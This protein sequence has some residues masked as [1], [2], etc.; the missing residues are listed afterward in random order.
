[1][2]INQLNKLDT[3][4]YLKF[5]LEEEVEH[6]YIDA[7]KLL[8]TARFDFYGILIYIDHKV[9]GLKDLSFAKSVYFERTQA[10]TGFRFKENGNSKKSSFDVFLVALD[11]LIDA[12]LHDEFEEDRTYIPVDKNLVPLDGAHRVA[13]A[14]YFGR[15]LHILRFLKREY[16]FSGFQYLKKQLLP[17][18][19]ADTMA[20]E[21]TKW[22]DDLFVFF[23]WPQAHLNQ[24]KLETAMERIRNS[25]DELYETN[26]Y[27]SSHGLWNLMLQIY[28]HMDWI[29]NVDNGYSNLITKVDEVWA[30]NGLVHLMIVRANSCDFVMKI[31]TELRDFFE[32]GLSSIHSTDNIEETRLALSALLNPKSR[33]FLEH[34]YPTTYKEALR[35]CN[36]FRLSIKN[37]GLK[38]DDFVIDSSM[39]LAIYGAREANDLDYYCLPGTDISILQTI[40][41]V[42]EHD[43]TQQSFYQLPVKDYILNTNNY[44]CFNGLK[45]I[46]LQQL[47]LFKR[48][49]YAAIRDEKDAIDIKL[50]SNLLS[51][52][53]RWIQWII[54]QRYTLLRKYRIFYNGMYALIFWRRKEI[55]QKVGLYKPLKT[56]KTFLSLM[57][58]SKGKV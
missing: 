11:K 2:T 40:Q 38:P 35:L 16:Q 57:M 31:K 44:F 8:C 42:E 27:L 58:T 19:V 41:G 39:V 14:A 43:K 24:Q 48:T 1:M 49:R 5:S 26:Y 46:S 15:K 45:F 6:D 17:P 10:M 28:G 33:H 20:M 56:I 12:F 23:L 47:M 9:K 3:N 29:G 53:D 30:K 52:R 36:E 51:N 54:N 50:I 13:C 34:A 4:S 22:H 32:I 18:S 25:T 37:Q 55:L 7:R 21:A